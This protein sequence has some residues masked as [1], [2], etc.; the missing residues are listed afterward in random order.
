MLRIRELR[1]RN[2]VG[3]AVPA[4]AMCAA[5]AI[6]LGALALGILTSGCSNSAGPGEPKTRAELIPADAV[7][8]MPDTDVFVPVVNSAEWAD[9]VAMPGPIHT[10]GAEDS[11]FIAPGGSMFLFW[12][13][14]DVSVP[15][16]QQVG[17]GGTGIWVALPGAA[18]GARIPPL[19]AEPAFVTLSDIPSLEGCPTLLGTELWFC[20]IRGGA[21]AN[22]MRRPSPF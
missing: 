2:D 17:D 1:I 12:W 21:T 9:P 13:T 7:K 15:A 10:A 5:V 22:I 19:W 3:G 18:G 11:P 20:S 14:P 6:V 4:A 16:E 8:V